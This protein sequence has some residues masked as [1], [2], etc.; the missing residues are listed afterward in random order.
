MSRPLSLLLLASI[1]CARQPD[2]QAL[3]RVYEQALAKREVAYGLSDARTASAA[4]DL[5]LYI[6]QWCDDLAGAKEV[7]ARALAIDERALGESHPQTLAD[8]AELAGVSAPSEAAALWQRVSST[9]DNEMASK[10][11]AALGDLRESAGDTAGAANFFQ[12]ALNR[13]EAVSGKTAPRVA[14]RLN[15]LALVSDPSIAIPLLDRALAINRKAWGE[16]YPETA[17]TEVN[18]CGELLAAGRVA[19]AVRMGK[20]AL[21]NLESTL[22]TEHPRTAAAA[23]TLADA[24]RANKQFASAEK[25]YRQALA[26]DEAAYGPQHPETLADVKTLAGFLRDRG[27]TAEAALLEKRVANGRQ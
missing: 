26:V 11:F 9:A 27:R 2:P 6:R 18:L 19:A 8:A 10:A 7:L 5:G 20:L 17:A 21:V 25:L 14:V 3:R 4:R 23:S 16:R 15:S 22:G 12:L 1:L 24:L 13:E